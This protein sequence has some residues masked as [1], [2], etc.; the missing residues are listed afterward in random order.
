[1]ALVK[2]LKGRPR[3]YRLSVGKWRVFFDLDAPEKS[4]DRIAPECLTQGRL[5]GFPINALLRQ[6]R[7]T[8][9]SLCSQH[10]GSRGE[11]R[12]GPEGRGFSPHGNNQRNAERTL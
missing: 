7:G 9:F 2:R 10:R 3:E 5:S 8:G 12:C 11:T 4:R 6:Y 1:M